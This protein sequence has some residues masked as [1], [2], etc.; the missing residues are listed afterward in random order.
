MNNNTQ[1][2]PRNGVDF[3]RIRKAK[4]GT[5]IPKYQGGSGIG[6]RKNTNATWWANHNAANIAQWAKIAAEHPEM[7]L[8]ELNDFIAQNHQL[9]L[10]TK[11]NGSKAMLGSSDENVNKY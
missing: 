9:Y 2:S 5:Q 1:V 3:S 4:F 11:Y 10:S 6:N 8:E 7:T